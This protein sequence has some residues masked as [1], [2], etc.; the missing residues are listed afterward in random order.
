VTELYGIAPSQCLQVRRQFFLARHRRP[1][2][3]DGND[4]DVSP[5]GGGYLQPNEV[6][7][8]VKTPSPV[9]IGGVEPV[10]TNQRQQHVA[11]ADML[12]NN[13]TKVAAGLDAG[14]VDEDAILAEPRLQAFEH[15]AGLT[16]AIVASVTDEDARH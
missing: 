16:L 14:N 13:A 3:Q 2:H 5:Q 1:L 10:F 6:V 8:G 15:A 11:G 9:L 4:G 12:I 7:S